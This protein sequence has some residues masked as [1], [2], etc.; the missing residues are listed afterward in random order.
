MNECTFNFFDIYLNM[1][2]T[3]YLILHLNATNCSVISLATAFEWAKTN[4]H[5]YYKYTC[6]CYG[7]L[8]LSFWKF[9]EFHWRS[10]SFLLERRVLFVSI[11]Y[12]VESNEYLKTVQCV[13][14]YVFVFMCTWNVVPAERILAW[15]KY[16][17]SINW[18]RMRR[19]CCKCLPPCVV[20]AN[21]CIVC[22]A[23]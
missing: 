4:F 10:K 5:C 11:Y 16:L 13:F 3:R 9:L 22:V 23:S 21:L 17:P 8:F 18:E 2:Q 6:Q 20:Y 15:I 14:V 19:N 12:T 1:K 7:K